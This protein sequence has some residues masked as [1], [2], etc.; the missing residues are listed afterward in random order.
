MKSDKLLYAIGM[1][2]EDM[3]KEAAPIITARSVRKHTWLKP[4]MPIA[5]C[6]AIALFA[7]FVLPQI[8]RSPIDSPLVPDEGGNS[9]IIGQQNGAI[10]HDIDIAQIIRQPLSEKLKYGFWFH[11]KLMLMAKNET[12]IDINNGVIWEEQKFTKNDVESS[13][14]ISIVDPILPEGDYTTSQSVLVDVATKKITAYRT[15]YYYF[16]K[17]TKEFQ[18][19][20]STFYFAE[21]HFNAEEIKKMQNVSETEGEIQI[22]DFASPTYAH[23]KMPYINKLVF[24]RNGAG[25]VIE[26]EA[27][28]VMNGSNIDEDKSLERFKETN[29][30]L[31]ALM[32]SI[33]K[34]SSS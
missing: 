30:Q 17:N 21:N 27:D 8:N 29:N 33:C 9:I 22:G 3:V 31:I 28:V 24:L 26:A 7:I 15:I 5:A 23:A 4:L 32:K 12:G 2:D 19:S 1:I 10:Y 6:A 16:D 11:Q 20:F 34:A 14:S 25:I 13:L 18:N